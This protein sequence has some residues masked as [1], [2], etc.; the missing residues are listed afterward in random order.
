M[1]SEA[2]RRVARKVYVETE[3]MEKRRL[4]EG[5]TQVPYI[6]TSVGQY[7][8]TFF[9]FTRGVCRIVA[10]AAVMEDTDGW[11]HLCNVKGTNGS[12]A[13]ISFCGGQNYSTAGK[14]SEENGICFGSYETGRRYRWELEY[15]ENEKRLTA[16]RDDGEVQELDY[17]AD[18]GTA[19]AG[20]AVYL[21]G[22]TNNKGL[23]E[24]TGAFR[25]YG[26]QVHENGFLVRDLVPCINMNGIGGL[27]D[28]V[29]GWFL[30]NRGSGRI[31][32]EKTSKRARKM[33]F[34]IEKREYEDKEVAIDE[35]TIA[36]CFA[37]DHDK[38]C[39]E[40]EGGV[41]RANNTGVL[42]VAARTRFV[43]RVDMSCVRLKYAVKSEEGYDRLVI[44]TA[45]DGTQEFSGEAEGVWEGSLAEGQTLEISYQKDASI[46]AEGE[47]AEIS[48]FVCTMK[49]PEKYTA[50][51]VA[52]RVL[53]GYISIDGIARHFYGSRTLVPTAAVDGFSKIVYPGAAVNNWFAVF[54]GGS[55]GDDSEYS[56]VVNAVDR[57]LV[58][59]RAEA[60]S[61]EKEFVAGATAGGKYA[62]LAGG[63]G[64]R[65]ISNS[66]EA[67]D[68]KL[69]R[70]SMAD[71]LQSKHFHGGC[72]F[73][74]C[75]VFGH[76]GIYDNRSSVI[77]IYDE[78]L[79]YKYI[80]T[81][82]GHAHMRFAEIGGVLLHGGYYDSD[83]LYII[84]ENWTVTVST[85]Y[86]SAA[87]TVTV[88]GNTERYA[89]FI[90]GETKVVDAFDEDMTRVTFDCGAVSA[91][92]D[93]DGNGGTIDDV[94]V[95]TD[96]RLTEVY[97]DEL[98]IRTAEEPIV[99][100][101]VGFNTAAFG[102]CLLIAG[103][104]D[105]KIGSYEDRS[106]Y[107]TKVDVYKLK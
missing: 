36:E 13:S 56:S 79:A 44:T 59:H 18:N 32:A 39:F 54:G 106:S 78:D 107:V 34:G 19:A 96:G 64:N 101:T 68:E 81:S 16:R 69:T 1:K 72:T 91:A 5:Y 43:A 10:D 31:G 17:S 45:N 27:Y 82:T 105:E 38:Y 66:A 95:V 57:D 3:R 35:E 75:A 40:Q 22:K 60:L 8:N 14:I 49:D 80:Q 65:F 99:G 50:T 74:D 46:H 33:F 100:R 70:I 48:E 52:K 85:V 47:F 29:N 7:I 41:F 51:G 30:M 58:M 83:M 42:S 25:L 84:D 6:S 9:V 73:R 103:G 94:V 62:V 11:Q 20:F 61:R 89:L 98:T 28:M 67:Y 21:F 37:L 92:S 63:A 55:T 71:M 12:F 87:R 23:A 93:P 76:G 77:D 104:R 53:K 97:D 4:P 88:A 24:E 26:F 86:L 15:N 90:G 102:D 2:V